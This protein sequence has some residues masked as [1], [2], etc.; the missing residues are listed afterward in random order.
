MAEVARKR[1]DSSSVERGE[2]PEVAVLSNALTELFNTL[3]VSQNAYAVRVSLDKSIVSRY[4]RGRRIPPQDFINRLCREAEKKLGAPL[5]PEVKSRVARFRL[6]ALRVCDPAAYE[7]ES[8][9]A[10]MKQSQRQVQKLVRQQE[11]LHDLLGKRESAIHD[12]RG[13]LEQARQDWTDEALRAHR[14]EVELLEHVERQSV[15]RERLMEEIARLKVDLSHVTALRAEAE[16]RCD[17]LEFRVKEME[18]ELAAA[19][20]ES[21]SGSRLPLAALRGQLEELLEGGEQREVAREIVE[22]AWERP[23]EDVVDLLFWFW[24]RGD[25]TR[26]DRLVAEVVHSRSVEE[27]TELGNAVL[28][29]PQMPRPRNPLETTP[30][31]LLFNQGVVAIRTPQDIA[32]L[33]TQLARHWNVRGP[34]PTSR[35]LLTAL[36]R[37]DRD[38]DDIAE[39]ISRL[40]HDDD[41]A[42][43]LIRQTVS[44]RHHSGHSLALIPQLIKIKRDDLVPSFCSRLNDEPRVPRTD[45]SKLRSLSEGHHR[46]LIR[47]LM[48]V[49]PMKAVVIFLGSVC[50]EYSSNSVPEDSSLAIYFDEIKSAGQLVELAGLLESNKGRKQGLPS[51]C[52]RVQKVLKSW[53]ATGD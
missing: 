30:L 14:N 32:T 4:L 6:D 50:A 46:L 36:L 45:I 33:H 28:G 27:V 18:E 20:A 40:D 29:T 47:A 16:R 22:A 8:L 9:R 41:V 11:A 17:D 13:E 5:Q 38:V 1:R 44:F 42:N 51:A 3:G 31:P 10:E 43:Q 34:S 52:T 35:N 15:E 12:M 53:V 24:K 26:R 25:L 48:Q 2:V 37:S 23:I 49:L 7:L 19:R 21:D 39:V